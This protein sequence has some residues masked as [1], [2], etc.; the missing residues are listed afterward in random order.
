VV[1][2]VSGKD[3]PIL[4]VLN[5]VFYQYG[6]TWDMAVT[7]KYGD[8]SRLAR[9]AAESGEYDLV[10][11]YG[12]D[13]TQHE[14]ANGVFGT[15]VTMGVLPGGTGNGFA[16]ELQIPTTLQ[17]AV[18]LFCTSGNQ[19]LVDLAR[20]EVSD[21]VTADAYF[22]QRI[23]TGIEPEEQT[24]RD[25]KDRYGT[26]AYLMRDVDRLGKLKDIP[27]RLVVDGKEVQISGNKCYIV[28][29]ATAGTGL[30]ISRQFSISDGYLDIFM[31]SQ[32]LRSMEEAAK[33]F[34][35]TST[36]GRQ[37]YYWRGQKITI[38]ADP[39]QPVWADGEYVG[40]TPLNINVMPGQLAVAV[41]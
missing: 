7:R 35:Q 37:N 27:Y 34:F 2:P 22:I 30:S 4:N 32:T 6:V 13:G 1:N 31:L 33:R 25:M 14:V 20:F 15:G 36:P 11:G 10:A 17:S 24:S 28:N 39:S 12:G 29:S 41:P 16:N 38:E 21:P 3:Q 23:F 18:K 8:A 26:F 40:R 9:A 19:K 5:R